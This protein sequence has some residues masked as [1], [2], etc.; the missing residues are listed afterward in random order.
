M[1]IV[2]TGAG[3]VI[4]TYLVAKLRSS[5]HAVF[6]VLHREPARPDANAIVCHDLLAVPR[7]EA[8]LERAEVVI[9]LAA[10]KPGKWDS[11]ASEL[12]ARFPAMLAK[13]LRNVGGRRFV[14]ISSAAALGAAATNFRTPADDTAVD[15]PVTSYGQQKS[16]ADRELE[17]LSSDIFSVVSL[18]PPA[19]YA[20][21]R[22]GTFRPF[23]AAARYGIPLPVGSIENARSMIYL[24]NLCDAIIQASLS[25]IIGTYIVTDSSPISTPELYRHL[26]SVYGYSDRV[27][28]VPRVLLNPALRLM[29]GARADSLIGTSALNGARFA[30]SFEWSPSVN[31]TDALKLAATVADR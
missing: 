2:I 23:F 9:N 21:H 22:L 27:W 1:T 13:A 30:A 17:Q 12:N 6:S 25:S 4:G 24:P 18:R 5:G 3:G 16:D 28:R 11:D 26:L 10:R 29:M 8:I 31:M 20:P 7:L 14:Q 15:D 19:V